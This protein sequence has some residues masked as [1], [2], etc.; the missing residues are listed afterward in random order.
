MKLKYPLTLTGILA[1]G[2]HTAPLFAQ[3]NLQAHQHGL[4][5]L[6]VAISGEQIN[7]LL[8]SPAYNLVGFEHSPHSAEQHRSVDSAVDWLKHNPLV[9]IANQQCSPEQSNVHT[10]WQDK[11]AHQH[12]DDHH[13]HNHGNT[14]HSD[15]EVTQRL[16]CPGLQDAS[17]LD[18][19]LFERFPGLE[20]LNVQW[21]SPNGQNGARL[22]PGNHRFQLSR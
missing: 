19:G 6:Q 7:V 16:H 8:L 14:R 3:Q 22:T 13:E 21:V 9:N 2:L 4:A 18:T 1:L 20:Q 11:H 10:G 12:T 5:E 15:T 17:E